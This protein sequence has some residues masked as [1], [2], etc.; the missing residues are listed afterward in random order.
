MKKIAISV[1]GLGKAY[2]IGPTLKKSDTVL[3]AIGAKLSAPLHNFRHLRGLA[4]SPNG[5]DGS[6]FVWAIKDLCFDVPVGQTLGIIGPNGA[7]KSTLLKI[8]SRITLPTHGQ[9]Q[10]RGRVASLLEVGTGFHPELTGREN[11]FLNGAVLGMKRVEIANKLDEIIAFSGVERFLDTPVKF[12]SSGMK[13]RLAFSV[14]AQ[15]EPEILIVDEVLAVGDAEFRDKC[16]GKMRGIAAQ[17]RTVL[18]VS[19]SMGAI[20]S[21][22]TRAL[23]IRNGE[24]V[25]DGRP[26]EVIGRYL[27][28]LRKGCPDR[29]SLENPDRTNTGDLQIITGAIIDDAGQVTD[30]VIAGKPITFKISYIARQNLPGLSFRLTVV[31]ESGLAVSSMSTRLADF[32]VNTIEGLSAL[33]CTLPKNPFMLGEYHVNVSARYHGKIIDSVPAALSF[34]VIGSVFFPTGQVLRNQHAVIYVDQNW[35]VENSVPSHIEMA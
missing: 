8:L 25:D 18:F 35:Q 2:R 15:L 22:C 17:G 6:N 3:G 33:S 28:Q 29:F 10:I 34:T 11:I 16:L 13:V 32:Q 1:Q 7:G 14:A 12:Y 24:L 30:K 4:A 21:L 5:L 27:A 20:Q 31:N 19:H 26:Q 23:S 9:A